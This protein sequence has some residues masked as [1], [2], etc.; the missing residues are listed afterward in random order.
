MEN[1]KTQNNQNAD[2][3]EKIKSGEVKMKSKAYFVSKSIG[4]VLIAVLL[5]LL[6]IFLVS[7][8]IFVARGSGIWFMLGF[9]WQGVKMMLI[10]FPWFLVAVSAV[11]II[12]LEILISRLGFAYRRPLIYSVLGLVVVAMA[13]GLLILKTPLHISAFRAAVEGKLPLAGPLY[14]SYGMADT[15]NFVRGRVFVPPTN[16]QKMEIETAEGE[17]LEV[18][19]PTSTDFMMLKSGPINKDDLL[20]IMGDRVGSKIEAW[21]IRQLEKDEEEFF[22]GRG[23]MHRLQTQGFGQTPIPSPAR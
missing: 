2:L 5:F 7:F 10:Y 8:I 20:M 15:P 18:E 14:R 13:A 4:F 19:V 12:A 16:G 1:N 3:M 9:G 6:A 23:E 11:L 22:S 21:G 17:K